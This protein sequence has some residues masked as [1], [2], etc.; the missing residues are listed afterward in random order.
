MQIAYSVKKSSGCISRQ[1]GAVVTDSNYSVKSVGWNNSAQ[2]QVPCA[3]RSAEDLLNG[4]DEE[5]YSLYERND[6]VFRKAIEYKYRDLIEHVNLDKGEDGGRN[7]SFCFK[8]VQNEIDGEK[9]QVHTRALH[10]E[11][12]AF[13]QI[14]K[15]GGQQIKGGYLFT[16][17]S[18]CEL[19]AKKAYQLGISKIY[20]IDPYPGIATSHILNGGTKSP[21]LLL[22]RGAVGSAFHR[23]YQ[24][25][26]PYKD[27]LDMAFK[28]PRKGN[29][30]DMRI[31]KMEEENRA[32]RAQ[33]EELKSQLARNEV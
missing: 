28:I 20:Y 9:N 4:V 18:P 11:E 19:C 32:L 26:M 25:I 1:V 17:A 22:F 14:S 27:E 6:H 3:L 30:K 23:L 16:T 8:D 15:Y 31:R 29:G 2:G 12:N 33:V 24:P 21:E 10:A 7:L 13:L 5:A